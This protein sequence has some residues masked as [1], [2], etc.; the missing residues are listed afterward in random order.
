MHFLDISIF[1][2]YLLGVL[3]VGLYFLRRNQSTDD[4]FVGGRKMSSLHIGLSVVA[5][6]VGGG[7]SIGLGGLGFVM[8][9]SGSWLLFTGLLGAWIAGIFLIPRVFSLGRDKS[10]LTF[11]QLLSD[12]FNPKVA[13]LAGLIS[14]ISYLGFTSSQL[15]AGAKLAS[16]TFNGLALD[17]ALLLMG[18]IAVLYTS[19]GGMK[20]VIYTDTFQW[21]VLLTGLSFIALPFS[22]NAVGGWSVVRE[23]LGDEF[24]SMRNVSWQ[25]LVNWAFTILPIWFVG[26]TLYQRIYASRSERSARRAWF[27]AGLFE[28]PV[29]AFLGVILGMLSRVAI[30]Q[31]I[32]TQYTL[33]NIDP[34]LGL[35]VLLKTILPVGFLGIIMAVY[36]SAIMST[37]DSCLMASS[38]NILTDVLG[39]HR[40]K[41]SLIYSQILTLI[42][43]ILALL[44]AM[45]MENVLE[46]ML[47]SYAFMVS[48]L[49]VPVL[50]GLFTR[51]PDSQ[52]AMLAMIGGGTTTSILVIL[53]LPLPLELD[54]NIFGIAVSLMI[55][56]VTLVLKRTKSKC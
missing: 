45:R 23:T 1:I 53:E 4:Y 30:K 36:F 46:L 32:I 43:G 47:L 24:L 49:I 31:G 8:G 35:P 38:G 21:I 19:L 39:K 56:L 27:I 29:M 37:A 9:I 22:L 28:F 12:I 26:M 25:Q 44:L 20:A 34:E 14:A 2:L 17:Q 51:K 42:I 41:R 48:G 55:Y 7:F 40:G 52:A 3:G 18:V 6:D 10:F 50:A 15:L 16:S 33:A 5:T 13:L 54:A 11:P